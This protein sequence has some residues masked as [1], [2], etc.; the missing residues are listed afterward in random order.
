MDTLYT[1]L[2]LNTFKK[3]NL[4]GTQ[5]EQV[6]DLTEEREDIPPENAEILTTL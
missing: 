4:S 5:Q 1:P 6:Y 3:A 2:L